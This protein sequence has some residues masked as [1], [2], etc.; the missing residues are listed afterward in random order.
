MGK[1]VYPPEFRRR[2]V[3]LYRLEEETSF[4][5]VAR[6]L[7]CSAETVRVWVAQAEIDEGSREGRTSEQRVRDRELE[8]ENARL[9]K[10]NKILKAAAA[11]F[12][13]EVMR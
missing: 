8:R 13:N 11:Y 2:A 7:G 3:E 6:D 10:E 4:A 1:K 9:R 5:D 12:A